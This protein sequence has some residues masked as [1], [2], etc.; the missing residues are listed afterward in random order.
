MASIS[1]NK[2]DVEYAVMMT[3]LNFHSEFM[4]SGYSHVDVQWWTDLI[5]VTLTKTGSVPAEA[6][7][8]QSEEGRALLRQVHEA[9][10]T[11]CQEE[12]K[13]RIETVVDRKV[14]TM[15]TSLDPVSGSSRIAIHLHDAPIRRTSVNVATRRAGVDADRHR[16]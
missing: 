16:G 11:S 15:V 6:R 13:E 2:A 12:L 7:L 14:R 4:R 8:A 1:T 10:F 5:H 9:L 3:V